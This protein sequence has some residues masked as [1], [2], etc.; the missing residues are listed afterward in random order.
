M[1]D[2]LRCQISVARRLAAAEGGRRPGQTNAADVRVWIDHPWVP[3][4]V[5][6]SAVVPNAVVPNAAVLTAVA[7][8]WAAPSEAAQSETHAW[9]DHPSNREAVTH[10]GPRSEADGHRAGHPSAR[11]VSVRKVSVRTTACP[12]LV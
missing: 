2:R 3:S 10:L 1:A 11:T 6:P 9:E 8:I 7:L 4:A 5:V 12:R